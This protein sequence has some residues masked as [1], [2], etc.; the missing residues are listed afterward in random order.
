MP[1]KAAHLQAAADNQ[2][3]IDYLLS[4]SDPIQLRWVVVVAFYK[5]LHI[6]EAVF[7]ADQQFTQS[8]CLDHGERNRI[9]KT[10]NRYKQIWK[11]YRPLFQVSLVARYLQTN[12]TP[13]QTYAKFEDYMSRQ[14]VETE[15]I[16]HYLMQLE[17]TASKWI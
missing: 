13:S 9:L 14:K 6:V 4:S 10:T 16:N 1:T 12:A 3:T 15:I 5:S 2:K 8:H 17:K 7:D 11:M